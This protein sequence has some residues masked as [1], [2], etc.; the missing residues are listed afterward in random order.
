MYGKPVAWISVAAEGRGM[1]A[2]DALASVPGYLGAT[3]IETA[4]RRIPAAPRR[5]RAG[6]D[7]GD[8]RFQSEVA[9]V[10]RP[11]L[12]HISDR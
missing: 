5:N 2:Q 3:V 7:S 12:D 4:R 10:W 11:L 6:R 9:E 1:G 8:Q